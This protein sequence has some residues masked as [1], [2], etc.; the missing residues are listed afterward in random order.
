MDLRHGDITIKPTVQTNKHMCVYFSE[1]HELNT[2][3]QVCDQ[4]VSEIREKLTACTRKLNLCRKMVENN[5]IL[6]RHSFRFC[7]VKIPNFQL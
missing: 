7:N 3:I 1:V 5:L 2:I 6:S 4:T